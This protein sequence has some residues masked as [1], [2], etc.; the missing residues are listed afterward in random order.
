MPGQSQSN[1]KA[2]RKSKPRPRPLP[3]NVTAR[4]LALEKK[5]RGEM[6][7]QFLAMARLVPA[8]AHAHKLNKV[9]IVN[10]TVQHLRDQRAMCITAARDV[11]STLS[12]NRLLRAELDALCRETGR[13]PPAACLQDPPTSDALS[14]LL[15]VEM[16][17]LGT[18]SAGF[19]ESTQ[20]V[21][22]SV[23][24]SQVPA[25]ADFSALQGSQGLSM[26]SPHDMAIPSWNGAEFDSMLPT[27]TL[28]AGLPLALPTSGMPEL[29]FFI[30]PDDQV[31]PMDGFDLTP[32]M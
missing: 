26:S 31:L 17:P 5:K 30:D 12:E 7:E 16:Q 11:Q 1:V 23:P 13:Q 19:G 6:N 20:V 3:P 15:S 28:E 4:N 18:F 14:E 9:L 25:V 22:D 24:Q 2:K 21:D 29:P 27:L 10:E 32:F 8:L